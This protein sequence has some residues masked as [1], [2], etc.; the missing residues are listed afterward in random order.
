MPFSIH[1]PS[2]F[3]GAFCFL[4]ESAFPTIFVLISQ[5]RM[6][7]QAERRSHLDLSSGQCWQKQENT[8]IPLQMLQ[9]LCQ[10]SGVDEREINNPSK[11][12]AS[13]RPP[14]FKSWAEELEE[15]APRPVAGRGLACLSVTASVNQHVKRSLQS[16]RGWGAA[17]NGGGRRRREAKVRQ[18]SRNRL[19]VLVSRPIVLAP[20]SVL[21]R[22]R[23]AELV[24]ANL[25]GIR[26]PCRRALKQK[27]SRFRDRTLRHP[28]FRG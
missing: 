24:R 4:G 15:K 5:N 3:S 25:R 6:A 7:R 9:K 23:F 26:G 21:D 22:F 10:H 13:A 1:S 17:I 18:V 14:T 28:L 20:Y 2:A 16:A 27:P 11:C 12:R 8:T 19:C